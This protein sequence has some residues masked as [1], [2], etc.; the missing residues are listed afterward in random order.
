MVCPGYPSRSLVVGS[1]V[2]NRTT[3]EEENEKKVGRKYKKHKQVKSKVPIPRGEGD[4]RIVR[5]ICGVVEMRMW[6]C[7][8]EMRVW[9]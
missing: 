6:V 5:D 8:V 9:M 3:R 4:R 7:G 1:S 2:A